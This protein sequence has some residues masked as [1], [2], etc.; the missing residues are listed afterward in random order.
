MADL[1]SRQVKVEGEKAEKEVKMLT[2][3]T[4]EIRDYCREELEKVREEMQ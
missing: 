3:T 1:I 4:K 2:D